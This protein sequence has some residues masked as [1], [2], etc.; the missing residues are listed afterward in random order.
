MQCMSIRL[1]IVHVKPFA[2]KNTYRAQIAGDIIAVFCPIHIEIPD[3]DSSVAKVSNPFFVV[4][5]NNF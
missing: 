1:Y 2:L 4:N 5:M 3:A